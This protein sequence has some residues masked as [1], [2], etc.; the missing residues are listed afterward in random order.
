M[1]EVVAKVPISPRARDIL[2]YENDGF[3]RELVETQNL[4]VLRAYD[5]VHELKLFLLLCASRPGEYIPV[6]PQLDSKA[7]HPFLDRPE[8]KEFCAE[9]LKGTLEHIPHQEPMTGRERLRMLEQ[10]HAQ[11]GRHFNERLWEQ[12]LPVCTCRYVP[13]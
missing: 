13:N 3:V 5:Y 2:E 6:P 12:G 10:A 11:Y 1:P 8:F 7:L 9:R 4:S